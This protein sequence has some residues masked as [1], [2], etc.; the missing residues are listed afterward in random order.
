ME[1]VTQVI[2]HWTG[3][4]G[5]A[6]R[7]FQAL[8][9]RH[10][11]VH[12]VVDSGGLVWQM[13]DEEHAAYHAGGGNERSIGVEIVCSGIGVVKGRKQ[14]AATCHGRRLVV[15]DYYDRQNAAVIGL[16]ESIVARHGLPRRVPMTFAGVL[17]GVERWEGVCGHLHWSARKTDPGPR[18]FER[19]MEAGYD[20]G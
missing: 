8:D 20:Q 10:L 17:P 14:Y 5:S 7:V 6:L 19:L 1:K 3:G 16:V 13:C 12:Y 18:I 15:S 9:A 4:E 11:G 2:L